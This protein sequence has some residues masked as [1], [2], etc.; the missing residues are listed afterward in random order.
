MKRLGK[1]FLAIVA[2]VAMVVS[3]L[4]QMSPVAYA[5]E[6]AYEIYP[7]PHQVTYGEGDFALSD[8]VNVVYEE[9][10][11]SYTK[12]RFDE[13]MGVKELEVTTS[14]A[15]NE[16]GLNVLVGIQGS[17]GY[18]DQYVSENGY[19]Y[20][21]TL[22]D[23]LD[24]YFLAIN[25]GTIIVLGK[26]TDAAFYALTTLYHIFT[27]V[28]NGKILNLTIE[29]YADVASRGFIEGYYGNPWSTED[30][31]N[32][33]T[34]GGYYKL[35]S[36]FYAPKD[37]PKHNSNWRALY[38]KEEIESKI[39]PLAEAGNASKCRFVYALHPYMHNAIQ[40]TSDTAYQDDLKVM[41]NKFAQVIE[42]G[43]RQIAILADDAANVGGGNYIRTLEDMTEWIKEMQKTYPDLK[44][45][46]PFCT[47]EY[48]GNGE[49]YFENFPENVQIVMTGGRIW[50]E[51]SNAF[52]TTFTNNVGR[53]PYLW[54][55]WPCTDNSKKHLIMG[56]YTTFLHPGVNPDK[57]QGIV[58]NPMQQSEPSKVA[59]FG[60]ACYSWNIW[61]SEQE[62]NQAWYDSFKYVDHNSYVETDASAALRELSKHMI[63][64]NMDG[65]VTALQESV[66]LSPKLAAFEAKLDAGTV[67]AD[68]VDAIVAEFE[69]LQDAA[70]AYRT[71]AGDTNVKDQI[72][73]WLDCWDDTTEAVISYLNAEKA[74]LNGQDDAV[75]WDY[76][77]KGQAAYES[78][79]THG[80]HY[81]DHTEYAE[82]GV[83]HIV[84]FMNKLD[85]LLS[86]KVSTI[87]DPT[88]QITTF[89]TN[90]TD[91]PAG[92]IANV[93]DNNASTEIIF[94]NPTTI[95]EGT[96]VGVTY[97]KPIDVDTV[98]FRLGQAEN[99]ADT[100]AAAKVE[101]TTDGSNWV[102][103]N[104][105]VY[106][107][108]TE[109]VLE[110]LGLE[111]VV[112][113]RMI[114][115]ASQ[116]NK[117]LGVRDIVVN[118]EEASDTVNYSVIKSSEWSVYSTYAETNLYDGNDDSFV[119]YKTG[120]GDIAAENSYVGYNFGKVLTLESA[121]IVVGADNGDKISNYA[122]ETSVNES[123][124]TPVEGYENYHGTS[125]GKDI[126]D[127]NLNGCQAQYIRI[128]NLSSK[129]AWVKFS[130][131]TVTIPNEG[132]TENVY[133][134]TNLPVKTIYSDDLTTMVP[135]ANLVLAP[136]EYVGIDLGRI[137]DLAAITVAEQGA[138]TLQVSKNEV[139][140]TT[141]AAGDVTEDARYVRL[142]NQTG[143][144]VTVN[145]TQFEV[146]SNEVAAPSLYETTMGINGTWGIA[147]DTRNNGAAF[148]NDVDTTTEFGDLPQ[149]GQYIIYDLGQEREIS[150]LEIF[151]QD[152]AVNYIRDAE[153]LISNDLTDW[154]KVITIGDG[155]ENTNDA[156]I[157]CINSGAGYSQ[158]TSEY[159]N[160]VS[161]EGTIEATPAR[162]IKILMT[163]SNN[164]RAVVF[165][166]IA[167][168]DGEYV[169]VVN[170][171]T[172]ESSA[173]E[174]QGYV[175]QNMFDGDLTTAY[176]PDTTEVGYIKYTLS[177][178][179]EVNRIN[180][181]QKG[182]ISNAKVL[183]YVEQDGERDWVEAGTLDRSLN[184]IY[185]NYDLI[186]EMKI[187][188]ENGSVPTITEIVRFY[189]ESAVRTGLENYIESLDVNADEYMSASYA[190]FETKLTAAQAV[191]DD[192]AS[193]EAELQGAWDELKLAYAGLVKKGNP[194]LIQNELDKIAE[195]NGEDYTEET[196]NNLQSAVNAAN[197]S[198]G[199]E[200]SESQVAAIINELQVLQ[201]SLV[202]KVAVSKADLQEYIDDNAL[203]SLDTSLYLSEGADVFKEA[204]K[205]AKDILA[206]DDATVTEITAAKTALQ[207]A[208]AG[209][210]LRATK[211]EMDALKALADSYDENAYTTT[212]WA[213]F[214]PVLDEVYAAIE[215]NE[216]TSQDIAV[217]RA[218][219]E[220]AA[221]DLV[222]RTD[223]S[224]LDE[225]LD[226]LAGYNAD[227]YTEETYKVLAAAIAK[228]ETALKNPD[229]TKTEVD[230]LI[231]ELME[232]I[233]QLAA[234]QKPADSGSNASGSNSSNG[235]TT[236]PNT[237]DNSVTVLW[238]AV[239][240]LSIVVIITKKRRYEV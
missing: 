232:S 29:D 177:D 204:L 127:I 89:I 166:E 23:N 109:V 41:Q 32:L 161:I 193:T 61:E 239:A 229:I 152:S 88:I 230:A 169:S 108:P 3:M 141:V 62:A 53:G 90:R 49:S 38:T 123:D 142:I 11:D 172:F 235:E 73:Y 94:K 208:R 10:I 145:L 97:T 205:D 150:K 118:P 174:V 220:T 96:Y 134:N 28:T 82:V 114:A 196:W 77:S 192:A 98:I 133:T 7:A 228:V 75:V 212:S 106:T 102:A 24:S 165:N 83:Q 168:N 198:M 34:W 140:W 175:P 170:D 69:I 40:Y 60:N 211:S 197:A 46:L 8:T 158:A 151:C 216:S 54:I 63:N 42:A 68:D 240:V 130:E 72:V 86:K 136:N 47:Q 31:I 149:E 144:D 20:S 147:E 107:S 74:I 71:K 80:F 122:I 203:E 171:P 156:N 116:T 99:P 112:G 58:L 70:Q 125:S 162:Y 190:E 115:T 154:T 185:C 187:E 95:A 191:L 57:I 21:E 226:V 100:F 218:S 200:M 35:N 126:L 111:D 51:V 27:Q 195:L 214:K 30:R 36:Y 85:Q 33:M 117:W 238:L 202:T 186:L 184:K 219:L 231:E 22:F 65:R 4:P 148:D 201:A 14:E 79:K 178:N 146:A 59:I 143:S 124:W 50:G 67:T 153:I 113:I 129:H 13:V 93:L 37:D 2:A 5:A 217:L 160:K 64:Q 221:K 135:A 66:E 237:A 76:Y 173:I 222:R 164:N 139:D 213:E 209:L 26:D 233:D 92:D 215:E 188:W 234:V 87:V 138:L 179:L 17:E 52:T 155:V 18:V 183:L 182:E 15:V 167:I 194:Q 9:G 131:F 137:K 132:N 120:T 225:L 104:D 206:N 119:W 19:T 121:H 25:N 44:L 6:T 207:E 78:S 223:T 12:A 1:R 91:T 81:V 180:I 224:E 227:K 84:P 128:R 101:Y 103:V 48:M 110:D 105:T 56:G 43:V 199:D 189:E 159:P 55:N 163:A 45:L 176:R 236:S 210:V 157:T 39:K 181:I 16:N